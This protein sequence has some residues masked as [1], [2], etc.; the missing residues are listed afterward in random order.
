MPL[1]GR[2][3][4]AWPDL[5]QREHLS[6]THLGV[7]WELG[8]LGGMFVIVFSIPLAVCSLAGGLYGIPLGS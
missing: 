4:Y 5:R 2:E 8:L 1:H 6:V 7:G 3:A